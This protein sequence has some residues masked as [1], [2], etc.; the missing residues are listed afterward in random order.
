MLPNESMCII[1]MLRVAL[2]NIR[3]VYLLHF[4]LFLNDILSMSYFHILSF[5]LCM[6]L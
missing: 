5:I 1:F 3:G 6:N 2:W 4:V